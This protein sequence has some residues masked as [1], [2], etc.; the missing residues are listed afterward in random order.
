MFNEGWPDAMAASRLTCYVQGLLLGLLHF[1]V[2]N[3][4]SN[5]QL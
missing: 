4:G 1:I 5:L 2:A 3:E